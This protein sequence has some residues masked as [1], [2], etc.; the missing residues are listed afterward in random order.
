[1]RRTTK[2]AVR[3]GLLSAG[4]VCAMANATLAADLYAPR[5]GSLKDAE[6]SAAPFRWAGFYA[7]VHAGIANRDGDISTENS[8]F[9]P[10]FPLATLHDSSFIGGGQIGYNWQAG[11]VVVGIEADGSWTKLKEDKTAFDV[12]E[13]F[14]Q[15]TSE[16]DWLIT[17]RGRAGFAATPGM[18]LYA[19]AGL[20]IADVNLKYN[21]YFGSFSTSD[22]QVGWTA[23]LGAEFMI[24]SN[25]T[26]KAEYL[27]V[28]LDGT[29][30][31]LTV[32][33]EEGSPLKARIKA[34]QDINILR[35]G[36]NYKF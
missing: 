30:L 14:A 23:G 7:G 11:Q 19:T 26:V 18:L 28:Q 6:P 15:Y 5:G 27:H 32:P 24:G 3:V 31:D 35:A 12:F 8:T 21:S 17:I 29:K 10:E 22:T 2:Q 1:M 20:A 16:I 13:G 33:V 25:W 4:V 34:D 36:L 9:S